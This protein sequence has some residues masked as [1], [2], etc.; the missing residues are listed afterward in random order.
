MTCGQW[1]KRGIVVSGLGV[2]GA[3]PV[4]A[5][6]VEAIMRARER[7]E[8]TEQQIAQLDAIRQ[9]AVAQR[10]AEMARIA[11]LRSQLE[12]GQIRR[13]DLMA[14]ME[15]QQDAR[16]GRAEERRASI[17]SVLTEAQRESLDTMRRRVDRQRPGAGRAGPRARRGG[18]GR[19]IGPGPGAEP[20]RGPGPGVGLR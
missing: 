11:E 3:M 16:Q 18:P 9:E 13:S 19:G 8:L 4:K 10:S 6:S 1:I 5:Q 20:G 17:E 7:L 15:D 12:A 14:A 2:L